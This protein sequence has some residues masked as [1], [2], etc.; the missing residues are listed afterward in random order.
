ML[1]GHLEDILL[2]F[3]SAFGFHFITLLF[4]FYTFHTAFSPSSPVL[5]RT[6]SST[7][8][9]KI[10][11]SPIS[12]VRAALVIAFSVLDTSSSSTTTSTLI[13]GNK[14]TLYSPTRHCN[15]RPP[16]RP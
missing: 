3:L 7:G 6:A 14:S 13:L 1:L 4:Y 12:P 11:P 15:M 5:T 8:R 16:S 10:L 9:T 2:A